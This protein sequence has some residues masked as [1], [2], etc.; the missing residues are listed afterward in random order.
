MVE[1]AEELQKSEADVPHGYLG[2]QAKML[3]S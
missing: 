2:E 1:Y 3:Q